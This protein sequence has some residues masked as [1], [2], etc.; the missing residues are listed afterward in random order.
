MADEERLQA[1]I[2]SN[3][4]QSTDRA[5]SNKLLFTLQ[6]HIRDS[7]RQ[8]LIALSPNLRLSHEQL[9]NEFEQLINPDS[10][11]SVQSRGV[12]AAPQ[13]AHLLA[14]MLVIPNICFPGLQRQSHTSFGGASDLDVQLF[15]PERLYKFTRLPLLTT[16][17]A[18]A[19]TLAQADF[20]LQAPNLSFG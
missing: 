7:T 18:P 19:F 5:A 11:T 6:G 4:G 9:L 12:A 14:R 3:A 17:L 1:R 13:G 20:A 2:S 16:R 8:V 10:E 15:S